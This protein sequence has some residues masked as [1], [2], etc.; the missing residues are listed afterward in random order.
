MLAVFCFRI[1][2]LYRNK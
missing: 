2:I 1:A